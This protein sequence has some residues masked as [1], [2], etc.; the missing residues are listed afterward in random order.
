MRLNAFHPTAFL[1][2]HQSKILLVA[3]LIPFSLAL[4]ARLYW[5]LERSKGNYDYSNDGGVTEWMINYHGGFVRR[6]LPGS[7]IYLAHQAWNLGPG[8]LAVSVSLGIY[9]CF[10]FYL[11]RRSKG[12]VPMWSL[13]ATPLLAYPIYLDAV[14]VRKDCLTMLLLAGAIHMIVSNPRSVFN[15]SAA[16]FLLT[17]GILSHELLM[18]LGIPSSMAILYFCIRSNISERESIETKRSKGLL[19]LRRSLKYFAYV[20]PPL[21]A[22]LSVVLRHGS[23]ETVKLIG[24]SWGLFVDPAIVK[25]AS[26]LWWL[27][28]PSGYGL[29]VT[30]NLLRET[31]FSL[32]LWILV[33]MASVSGVLLV[34]LCFKNPSHALFFVIAALFQFVSM[35]VIFATALDQGRWIMLSLLSA[36]VLVIESSEHLRSEVFSALGMRIPL[37]PLKSIA[38]VAPFGLAVWGFPLYGWSLAGWLNTSPLGYLMLRVHDHLP[39]L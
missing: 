5:A 38:W 12:I 33:V 17:I 34:T 21:L 37:P 23:K 11:L 15:L 8:I 4:R 32:P 39:R 18:A 22:S 7:V 29:S 2:Q 36:F 25:H 19:T 30:Q 24:A 14:L 27:E 6:G 9:L 28:K 26:A 31:H 20:L 1:R 3:Y 13:F 16:S 10:A 35:S